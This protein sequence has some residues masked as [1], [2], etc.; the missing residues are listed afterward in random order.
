[1]I[2][3]VIHIAR[4]YLAYGVYSLKVLYYITL[5]VKILL[6]LSSMAKVLQ[7]IGLNVTFI[8]PIAASVFF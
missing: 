7:M 2:K 3:K 6:W 5:P 1:V 4:M 8:H